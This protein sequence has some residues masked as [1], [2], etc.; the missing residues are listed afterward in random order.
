MGTRSPQS[1][2]VGGGLLAD[3]SLSS[4]VCM[5]HSVWPQHGLDARVPPASAGSR[6]GQWA[7]SLSLRLLLCRM[8]MLRAAEPQ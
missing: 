5:G 2:P 8:K 3:V 6:V 1:G 7:C 4:G